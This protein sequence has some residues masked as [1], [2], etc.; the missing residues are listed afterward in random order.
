MLL[1]VGDNRVNH[2]AA[3]SLSA[4]TFPHGDSPSWMCEP[5]TFYAGSGGGR[6]FNLG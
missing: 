1:Y 4:R 5:S 2:V 3:Q 6:V